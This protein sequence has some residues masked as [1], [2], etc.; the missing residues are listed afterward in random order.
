MIKDILSDWSVLI[1]IKHACLLFQC[2]LKLD[3]EETFELKKG[4]ALKGNQKYGKRGGGKRMTKRVR[5]YLEG[6]FLAGNMNKSDRMTAS[7]MVSELQTLVQEGE[8]PIEEV[9]EKTTIANW[10]K[11]YAASLK[12]LTAKRTEEESSIIRNFRDNSINNDEVSSQEITRPIDDEVIGVREKGKK[13]V[14]DDSDDNIE[15]LTK[16]QKK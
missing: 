7:E 11:R 16:R 2:T 9:P 6:Y 14:F 5:S 13:T 3:V 8:I 12:Q 10:I 4:W 1:N 15:H